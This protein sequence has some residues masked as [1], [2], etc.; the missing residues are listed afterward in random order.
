MAELLLAHKAEV[1]AKDDEGETPLHV[2]ATKN[3]PEHEPGE[4][5]RKDVAELL[6]ASGARVNA[7]RNDGITPLG[8]AEMTGLQGL[9]ELLRQH[10]GHE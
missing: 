3:D 1:N 6:L 4:S 2:A 7:K 10:G 8:L 5:A 9:A